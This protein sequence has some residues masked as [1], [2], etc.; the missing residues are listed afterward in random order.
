MSATLFKNARIVMADEVVH[1]CVQVVDGRIV[2]IDP[3]TPAMTEG[4][5]LQ[6]D[7]LMPG[8]VEMH[9]DNFERHLMPRP[10]VQWAEMPALLAHDAEVAAAALR[11]RGYRLAVDDLGAGGLDGGQ[12]LGLAPAHRATR[13]MAALAQPHRHRYRTPHRGQCRQWRHRAP[14]RR[15]A[16]VHQSG[17]RRRDVRTRL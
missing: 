17:R 5:D 7:Y 13:G 4:I 6:G 2:T 15:D 1:G 12:G 8:F 14:L 9:T 3:G 10:K 16:L 11:G